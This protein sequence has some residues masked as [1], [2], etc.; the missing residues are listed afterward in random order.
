MIAWLWSDSDMELQF[1]KRSNNNQITCAS[2][3][4]IILWKAQVLF[5]AFLTQTNWNWRFF[6]SEFSWNWNN[7]ISRVLITGTRGLWNKLK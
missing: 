1:S 7:K 5:E 6:D 3:F 4:P 2:S